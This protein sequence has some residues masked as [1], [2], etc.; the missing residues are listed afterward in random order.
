VPVVGPGQGFDTQ[1]LRWRGYDVA[2]L[3]IGIRFTPDFLMEWL[4]S[5]V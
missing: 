3:D 2:T 5:S 1:V 4:D